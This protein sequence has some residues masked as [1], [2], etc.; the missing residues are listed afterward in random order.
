MIYSLISFIFSIL[1]AKQRQLQNPSS[2]PF[3]SQATRLDATRKTIAARLKG[4]A[5]QLCQNLTLGARGK[6]KFFI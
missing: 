6:M 4:S 2:A 1:H 5:H 3:A